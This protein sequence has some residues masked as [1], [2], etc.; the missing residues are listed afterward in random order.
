MSCTP[1]TFLMPTAA[2]DYAAVEKNNPLWASTAKK[3]HHLDRICSNEAQ[4]VSLAEATESTAYM[5]SNTLEHPSIPEFVVIAQEGSEKSGINTYICYRKTLLTEDD[6]LS[7]EFQEVTRTMI[8]VIDAYVYINNGGSLCNFV[9]TICKCVLEK[10]GRE[11]TSTA[12]FI[13][14]VHDDPISR[15]Y[16]ERDPQSVFEFNRS[17]KMVY[18]ATQ[19]V[20]TERPEI[21]CYG[22]TPVSEPHP[23]RKKKSGHK[24]PVRMVRTIR[25]PECAATL[26][27]ESLKRGPFKIT[28]PCWGVAGHWRTYKRTGKKVWIEPYR[29]GKR[30]NDPS[31]YQPKN[32]QIPDEIKEA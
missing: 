27:A 9:I 3:W 14:Y 10:D 13:T 21:L 32:Y 15:S 1:S 30:R 19:M 18:L 12:Q 25:I 31:A 7:E 22:R 20:S 16:A 23:K 8:S 4:L 26:L 17:V 29:K 28:C 5:S 11:L 6:I 2:L 24:S